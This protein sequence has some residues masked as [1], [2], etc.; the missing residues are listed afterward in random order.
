MI[1]YR[2]FS[3]LV[4]PK[5]FGITDFELA[6]RDLLNYFNIRKGEKLMQPNFGTIIWSLLFEPLTDG[7]QQAITEDITKIVG[8]DPRLRVG[9]VA[10]LQQTNGFLVQLTLYYVPTNQ[11]ENIDLT[12]E[13]NAKTLTTRTYYN[14]SAAPFPIMT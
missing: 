9:Q 13:Q 1:T 12:F 2:G 3:T 6:K 8:Y 4:S 11:V 7:I 5:R 10:V 14:D